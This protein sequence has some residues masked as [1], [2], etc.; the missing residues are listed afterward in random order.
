MKKIQLKKDGGFAASDALI[1]ILIITLFTGIIA[2]LLYNIYLSNTSLKRMS[3]ANQYVIDVL[4]YAD[5]IYYDDVEK[6]SLKAYFNEK[7]YQN[8]EVKSTFIGEDEPNTPYKVIIDVQNYNELEGNE[9][10]LDLVKEITVTVKYKLGS[11]NQEIAVK[12]VKCREKLVTPNRPDLSLVS[13]TGE[14]SVY[15]IKER[16]GQYLVCNENDNSWYNYESDIPAMIVVTETDLTVG[17][18]INNTDIKYKWIPRYASNIDNELDIKYL[19]SNTN[20]YIE[21]QNGYQVLIDIDSTYD[22][23]S[24]FSGNLIGIWE[25]I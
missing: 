16:N 23:D 12:K 2:T 7:Y 5:K 22:I 4:E 19:Y 17:D 14:Q 6:E 11:R 8:T 20:K 13:V 24:S 1:A 3:K 10:K 21:E 18:V 15:P 25:T 9:N